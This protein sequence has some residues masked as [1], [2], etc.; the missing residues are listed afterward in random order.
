MVAFVVDLNYFGNDIVILLVRFIVPLFDS[1]QLFAQILDYL[2]QS[3]YCRALA[4]QSQIDI[5]I[6]LVHFAANLGSIAVCFIVASGLIHGRS[7]MDIVDVGNISEIGVTIGCSD[8]II[9][10]G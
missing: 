3:S 1:H 5:V 6:L 8:G 7:E 4:D 9:D 10:G 2:L